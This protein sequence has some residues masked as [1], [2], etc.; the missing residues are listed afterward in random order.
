MQLANDT[1]Y[2]CYIKPPNS[3]I[4]VHEKDTVQAFSKNITTVVE[5]PIGARKL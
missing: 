4:C 5:P 3:P 1:V 2:L